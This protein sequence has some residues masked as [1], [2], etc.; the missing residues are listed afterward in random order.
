MSDEVKNTEVEELEEE[1]KS[2]EKKPDPTLEQIELLNQSIRATLDDNASLKASLADTQKKLNDIEQSLKVSRTQQVEIEELDPLKADVPDVIKQNRQM[3]D[4]IRAYE[5][6]IASLEKLATNFQQTE[7]MREAERRKQETIERI[8]TPLDE[9]FGAKF[10]NEA[11]KMADDLVDSGKE[12]QP[13]TEL[14]AY[15]LMEKC[16]AQVKEKSEKTGKKTSPVPADNGFGGVPFKEDT[17]K[18]GTLQE[19]LSEMRKR[20]R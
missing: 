1:V 15:L 14:A 11:K 4:R 5:G 20:K 16:Y 7:Q 2:E 19:V 3:A 18:E 12:P 9:K 6:R 17:A 10:R 8:L 13:N